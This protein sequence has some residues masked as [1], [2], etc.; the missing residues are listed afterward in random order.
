MS[1]WDDATKVNDT[2]TVAKPV[3]Q[4]N[5]VVGTSDGTSVNQG[6]TINPQQTVENKPGAQIWQQT[7]GVDLNQKQPT[8]PFYGPPAP[9]KPV[10]GPPV[11]PKPLTVSN[12]PTGSNPYGGTSS[13][14]NAASGTILNGT[15][16]WKEV[17]N[18]TPE[19]R[20]NQLASFGYTPITSKLTG[21]QLYRNA[22]GD[23]VNEEQAITELTRPKYFQ[24]EN[25][26]SLLEN[27]MGPKNLP[28]KG[29]GFFGGASNLANNILH[30]AASALLGFAPQ[31]L[32]ATKSLTDIYSE[33]Q[34][35]KKI[36]TGELPKEAQGVT[37]VFD[38]SFKQ[39]AGDITGTALLV[40]GYLG[41]KLADVI[42]GKVA[43]LA[44]PAIETLTGSQIAK[45][46]ASSF[47]K[48][49][50]SSIPYA[51]SFT[52]SG[53]VNP[54]SKKGLIETAANTAMFATFGTALEHTL[55]LT[56]W[57]VAKTKEFSANFEKSLIDQGVTP[58]TAHAMATQGGFM[59]PVGTKLM[60]V[61]NLN[62][63]AN[64]PAGL[65]TNTV[66]TYKKMIQSGQPVEPIK[67][68]KESDGKFYIEDGKNRYE[69]YKQSGA[70]VIPVEE[71]YPK[72]K[73]NNYQEPKSYFTKDSQGRF[74]GSAP[75]SSEVG[76]NINSRISGL[77]DKWYELQKAKSNAP[78][79]SIISRIEKAQS[80]IEKQI[81]KTKQAGFIKNPFSPEEPT[82]PPPQTKERG[83]ITS[84][85][86]NPATAEDL[87]KN[88]EGTYNVHTDKEAVSTAQDLIVRDRQAAK[89]LALSEVNSKAANT[90]G[91]LL[92]RDA[93]ERY[94]ASV[95]QNQPDLAAL[96][97]AQQ[98]AE[99]LAKKGTSAGQ[100]VQSFSL[101]KKKLDTPEGALVEANKYVESKNRELPKGK[102]P[103]K[104]SETDTKIIV[105][106]AN[107][108]QKLPEGPEKSY[109][110][111]L[112][113]FKISD[114]V[115][116]TIVEK[117]ISIWKAGLVSALP[118]K[119]IKAGSEFTFQGM[120]NV[121]DVVATGVDKL[122]YLATGVRTKSASLGGLMEQFRA[123]KPG[124]V[125]AK[126]YFLTG[127]GSG[128]YDH[129]RTTLERNG[130][131]DFGRETHFDN[132][133][134]DLYVNGTFRFLGAETKIYQEMG[135]KAS[136]YE[137]AR[138]IALNEGKKGLEFKGRVKELYLNPTD[139]MAMRAINEANYRTFQNDNAMSGMI[140]SAKN[141]LKR[142]SPIGYT[143]A[144]VTLPFQKV[145]INIG[146]AALVDY[147]PF[148]IIKAG[149]E[150]IRPETRGQANLVET[151]S[152]SITGSSVMVLGAWLAAKGM[153][154]GSYPTS[155]IER[156]QWAAEGKQ[157]NSILIN[158]RW[159]Q[160]GRVLGPTGELLGLGADINNLSQDNHG[161]ALAYK[162]AIEGVK[163]TGEQPFLMGISSTLQGIQ[164]PDVYG[165]KFVEGTA[166]S[167]VPNIITRLTKSIDSTQRD[168]QGIIQQVESRIPF[169]SKT[170]P[171]KRDLFG[172]PITNPGD[173]ASFF[174]PFLSRPNKSNPILDEANRIGAS[175]TKPDKTLFNTKVN[176]KEY[177][178]F[179][180]VQGT[181]VKIGLNAL[182]ESEE[183]KNL[184]PTDQKTVFESTVRDLR[185]QVN[186][187]VFPILMI[188]R[189]NLPEN[190]DPDLIKNVF[191]LLGQNAKFKH[192][193]S[194]KQEQV[195]Q[196]IFNE[197]K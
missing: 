50:L 185:K 116:S 21:R 151:L 153:M 138:V 103:T 177:D 66:A 5:L 82:I 70:K 173:D 197:N 191:S 28:I 93:N 23:V 170:L 160:L 38:K 45:N 196:K 71:V 90:T 91:I 11:P 89:D 183:Y 30:P 114:L 58:E 61:D 44:E 128:M 184:S 34:I 109:K 60:P 179:M 72:V 165:Q 188:K 136:L 24:Q 155:K 162:T 149:W 74:T 65:D 84:I 101:L 73:I 4:P 104:I 195:I 18:S 186:A 19:G 63:H 166:G 59:K 108:I 62:V 35:S 141:Y 88:I 76:M 56:R 146:K 172:E 13:P 119:F 80:D 124:A 120:V 25:A 77:E 64:E 1:I 121:K 67:I 132:K 139:E 52:A 126:N 145:P 171:A 152:K 96:K 142:N 150:Q 85:K 111:S 57:T 113:A 174:D 43:A 134:L 189:Y 14:Q 69:A 54:L 161:I 10:F 75:R 125:A 31:I 164:N 187:T 47:G 46:I 163:K 9:T 192:L 78:N 130:I 110:K 51:A 176:N 156:D 169:L 140:S 20:Q 37:G 95:A 22:N 133:Y 33:E 16:F 135:L 17:Q 137:Q 157:A 194:S 92:L 154:T 118:T 158:G 106:K 175:I 97:E 123:I 181:V 26:N 55:P 81:N 79:E 86:E 190:A 32:N 117:G 122:A 147:T 100:A 148:G 83:F 39:W 7:A 8:L 107:E 143:A 178:T 3:K 36:A 29:Q 98:Y 68:I 94:K 48:N 2:I 112:L 41:T 53:N 131:Y 15:N 87:A 99:H 168:P 193:S 127:S 105:D 27:A 40:G 102:E 6:S 42:Y 12:K 180:K 167:L 159:Y 49:V 182:I 115:P 129:F 144:E